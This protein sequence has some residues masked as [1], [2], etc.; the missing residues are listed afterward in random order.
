MSYEIKIKLDQPKITLA[1]VVSILGGLACAI[2]YDKVKIADV[3]I[4]LATLLGPIFAVQIQVFREAR[5]A[6]IQEETEKIKIIRERQHLV[7][8]QMMAYRANPLDKNFVQA[9]NVIRM[10]FQTSPEVVTA[11][12]ALFK[13]LSTKQ[14]E[15][16]E[17][18]EARNDLRADLLLK[19]SNVLNYDFTIQELKNEGY[20]A[21]AHLDELNMR[22]VI[23]KNMH[24]I[25]TDKKSF[26]I[27]IYTPPITK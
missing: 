7:F 13:N 12:K 21:Q 8:R 22:A 20:L 25:L 9:F 5:R 11:W 14:M 3:A 23:L 1:I 4:I 18:N 16:P 27:S 17:H 2:Y 26:P 15:G 19:M 24:D 6:L 10:D